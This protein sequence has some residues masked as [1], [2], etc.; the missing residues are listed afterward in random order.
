MI[1]TERLQETLSVSESDMINELIERRYIITYGTITDVVDDGLVSVLCSVAKDEQSVVTMVCVLGNIASSAFT[2]NVVPKKGDKVIVFCPNLFDAKMFDIEQEETIIDSSVHGYSPLYSIAFPFN[3]FREANHKNLITLADGTLTAKLA[4]DEN[5]EKNKAEVTIDA[6][7]ALTYKNE[8][9]TLTIDASGNVN[10]N[11]KG[12]Y[13]IKNDSTDLKTVLSDLAT[14]IK[15]LQTYGSPATHTVMPSS[16]TA[17][18]NWE[19][20]ELNQLL[21]SGE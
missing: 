19:S 13:V 2:L 7:G 1:T 5:A 10:I 9:T 14:Q 17:I 16:Q 6:D 4:Y 15:N 11:T 21:S 20:G 3:Q 12:K 18:S 8:N